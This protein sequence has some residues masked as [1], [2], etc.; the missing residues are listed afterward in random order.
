MEEI[1]EVWK[2]YKKCE[3]C[4]YYVSN[5]GRVKSITCGRAKRE[6]IINGVPMYGRL[7]VKIQ[8]KL[9][10]IHYLV[11]LV[12]IGERPEG[13][14][15]DHINRNKLDNR[16]CNL[17]YCT[18]SENKKN[19]DDYRKDIIVEGR[20]ERLKILSKE[21]Q[22]RRLKKK[23]NCVCGSITSVFNKIAHEKT[24]THQNWLANNP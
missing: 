18:S 16:L 19:R 10:F 12:F 13:L 1:E 5:F 9:I 23:I 3:R 11:L 4:T 24:K 22:E 15:I 2:E 17:K 14:E 8:K 7:R 6:K 20:E 21:S